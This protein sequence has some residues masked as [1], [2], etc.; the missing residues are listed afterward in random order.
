MAGLLGVELVRRRQFN[1][2]PEGGGALYRI[3]LTAKKGRGALATV[4]GNKSYLRV[5]WKV[6]QP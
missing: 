1:V 6:L 3:A 5:R 4:R 2:L